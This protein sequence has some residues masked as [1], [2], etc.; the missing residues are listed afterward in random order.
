MTEPS[1][2]KPMKILRTDPRCQNEDLVE[3][4]ADAPED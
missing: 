1:I 4:L 3:V 2:A